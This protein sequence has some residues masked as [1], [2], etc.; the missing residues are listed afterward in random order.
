M[1]RAGEV[2]EYHTL[3]IRDGRILDL[4]PSSE[5]SDRYA[6]TVLVNRAEHVLLP[7]LVNAAVQLDPTER[8]ADRPTEALLCIAEM[9]RAGTTCVCS[10]GAFADT[11]ARAAAEQGMR[12]MLGMQVVKSE[13]LTRALGVRDEYRGHPSIS[14]AFAPQAPN[15]IADETF[16][17]IAT[18]ADELDAGILL[19]LHK[20]RREI[21]ESLA[22]HGQRPLERLHTLGLLTPALTAAHMAH[23]NPADIALA[24]E[25]GI[26]ITLCPQSDLRSG[27]GAPPFGAWAATGLRLGIGSGFYES[28]NLDLW[29]EARLLALLPGDSNQGAS[30]FSPWDAL[31]VA[32]RGGAAALGLDDDIGTVEIGKWADMCCIDLSGPEMQ[33]SRSEDMAT[34]L[35]FNGGRDRV[36]DVWV[37]GRHL[38]NAGVFTRLDWPQLMARLGTTLGS[39]QED[40]AT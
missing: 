33:R 16:A 38:L 21:E 37:C 17:R 23:L 39:R 8:L 29:S 31:A 27:N 11:A 34:R 22:L 15:L 40:H 13:D 4:L 20:S 1:V 3:V 28:A 10:T 32:T 30:A 9:L 12:V 24:H 35:V 36:S 19:N 7:G 14:T 25:S 18:L 26:A 6:A 2:L 5:A